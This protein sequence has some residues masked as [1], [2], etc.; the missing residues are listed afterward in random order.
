[1]GSTSTIGTLILQ[2]RGWFNANVQ[3]RYW[4]LGSV[5]KQLSSKGPTIN[6]GQNST[7]DPGDLGV[8]DGSM[9][10]LHVCVVW[11]TDHDAA[12]AYLYQKGNLMQATYTISGTTL[13]N[14]LTLNSYAIPKWVNWSA[15]LVYSFPNGEQ[16]YFF[17]TNR[18][19]L[20][21]IVSNAIVA[22]VKLRTSGQRHSQPPLV[23]NDNRSTSNPDPIW[24]V[25]MS[26]YADLGVNGDERIVLDA[27]K[28]LVTVNT[29][30]TES[31]LDSFLTKNN[32]M[33]QTVTA[34]GFFS[35]GGM[36]AIDVHGGTVSA[37][38]FAETASAFS[39][40][41]YKGTVNTID[42]STAQFGSFSPLQFARVS[43]G[44][45]GIVTSVTLTVLDRPWATTF[46]PGRQ[47]YM[48]NDRTSFIT[49]FT[50]LL[51]H[52]RIETFF[53]PYTFNFLSLWW[54]I[55]KA[56]SNEVPNK[57][58][59]FDNPCQ[60]AHDE[61]YGAPD[62]GS[63]EA[64]AQAAGLFAQASGKSTIASGIMDLAYM[65][66]EGLFDTAVQNYSDLWLTKAARVIFMSYFVELPNIDNA[67]VGKIW[68]SINVVATELQNSQAFLIA[69]PMEFRFVKGGN[70]AMAGTYT[71]NANST[72]LNLDL[73][74][75][76]PA[77][78][79]SAYPPAL[80]QFFANVERA[81]VNMGGFPHNG[82]MYGFYD[83]AVAGSATAPFNQSYLD[84]L[85]ARRGARLTA[86][87]QY[88]L[89]CD[90][91][92]LFSNAYVKAL[93]GH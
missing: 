59:P 29:G 20:Q 56:P 68:D 19:E 57:A 28:N 33:L 54:D 50:P 61:D 44:A 92:G 80:L 42:A 71:T 49:Q 66:I 47:T 89:Q 24:L 78:V 93:M 88:R 84:S 1:M 4:P 40:M 53:N 32:K 3:F 9:V 34:G 36:T 12:E 85:R 35:L 37:P 52:D 39:I 46:S 43:L 17:P 30:V 45:L 64:A 70:T 31:E 73:I 81:W 83:P 91:N 58:M 10:S 87:D 22:K 15:N 26:C 69:G 41:D 79:A 62:E 90:P 74:A 86:F 23:I 82:K 18:T 7:V 6:G 16:E 63:N 55:D 11:G 51:N 14:H 75:F 25:D 21:T 8:P 67:G 65:E 76:V 48:L 72:F 2:D 77:T 38:I 60:T 5:V 13:S 27:T